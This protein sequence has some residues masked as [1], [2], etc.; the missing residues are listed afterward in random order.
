[1]LFVFSLF[2]KP[3]V[4]DNVRYYQAISPSHILKSS[5]L[6]PGGS[7]TVSPKPPVTSPKP[8]RAKIAAVKAKFESGGDTADEKDIAPTQKRIVK[9]ENVNKYND[10]VEEGNP[11]ATAD[12]LKDKTEFKKMAYELEGVEKEK[13]RSEINENERSRQKNISDQYLRVDVRTVRE[14][15][16]DIQ[17]DITEDKYQNEDII[18]TN[19]Q[20]EQNQE[21]ADIHKAPDQFK[22]ETDKD[23]LNRFI[24]GFNQSE[25]SEEIESKEARDVDVFAEQ[26]VD[27]VLENVKNQD[28]NVQK[29]DIP[30]LDFGLLDDKENEYDLP[31]KENSKE[32]DDT[33]GNEVLREFCIHKGNT[34]MLRSPSQ[35]STSSLSPPASPVFR[36]SSRPEPVLNFDS[37]KTLVSP[38]T[39]ILPKQENTAVTT[40][41]PRA[42]RVPS[43]PELHT[44]QGMAD[45]EDLPRFSNTQALSESPRQQAVTM[46]TD[47]P[48]ISD[49][50]LGSDSPRPPALPTSSIPDI[51]VSNIT[52][53][54]YEDVTHNVSNPTDLG[55][56]H[57]GYMLSDFSVEASCL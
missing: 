5:V 31:D 22:I 53:C 41:S 35:G 39:S 32:L 10:N 25:L 9:D 21:L 57:S 7:S 47:S 49:Q 13:E 43:N 38:V 27:C 4:S 30:K 16:Y 51:I 17:E 33:Q 45:K 56:L 19:S 46:D 29:P 26:I 48:R 55:L 12:E 6:T 37:A 20:I 52:D 23:A 2:P 54:S 36:R 14:N 44:K 40:Y 50:P 15:L 8:S 34:E 42:S 1:M 28:I 3:S 11:S 24:E 18:K